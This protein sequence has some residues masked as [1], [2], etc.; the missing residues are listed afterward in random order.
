MDILGYYGVKPRIRVIIDNDFAGDPDDLFQTAHHLLSPSVEIRA[1]I[2]SHL[3]EGD[4]FDYSGKTA[5]HG[6]ARVQE[7]IRIMKIPA[8][9]PVLEGAEKPLSALPAPTGSSAAE[10]IVAEALREDTNLPL[11]VLCGGGLTDLALAIGM[12][13]RITRRMTVVWIGG[14]EYPDL[15]MPPPGA[16]PMEYNLAI[17]P[18]AARFIFNETSVPLWQVPRNVYRQA[19]ISLMELDTRV[20]PRGEVGRYLCDSITQIHGALR[21]FGTSMG[22]TYVL[23]DSPLV[24]LTALQSTCEPDPASSEYI[25]RARPTINQEG[26]YGPSSGNG[27]I[28]VYTRIDTRLMFEDFF[29][30]L[31]VYS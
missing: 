27:T 24:L 2:G 18:E 17:D 29:A 23:G 22:E 31:G 8:G 30:K 3:R 1:I 4:P 12:D 14:S 20:R 19:G 26:A 13:K 7:L 28:R 10:A 5:A 11:F 25:L 9:I 6:V 15:A 21:A 16:G